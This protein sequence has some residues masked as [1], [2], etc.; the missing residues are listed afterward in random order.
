MIEGTSTLTRP[1]WK[2]ISTV[3]L[4]MGSSPEWWIP[5]PFSSRG[6]KCTT[7]GSCLRLGPEV[8]TWVSLYRGTTLRRTPPPPR[9]LQ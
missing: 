5:M 4:R 2:R 9:T 8:Y 1:S 6:R 3:S 7:D